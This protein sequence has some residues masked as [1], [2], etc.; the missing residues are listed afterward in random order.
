MA[1]IIRPAAPLDRARRLAR[2]RDIVPVLGQQLE[3]QRARDRI[4]LG[5]PEAQALAGA[6]RKDEAARSF[7]MIEQF[8]YDDPKQQAY[9][10]KA[11]DALRR[12][13]T[14]QVP[15]PKVRAKKAKQAKRVLPLPSRPKFEREPAF[16]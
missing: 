1:D 10:E 6:G 15:E 7:S 2:A 16:S 11:R 5:E 3:A 12:I 14:E 4:R 9:A 13:V 8:N